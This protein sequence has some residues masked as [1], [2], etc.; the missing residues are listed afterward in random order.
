M[1]LSGFSMI[2]INMFFREGNFVLPRDFAV[3]KW[4][5]VKTD[6]FAAPANRPPA[7]SD[8]I[9]WA[10]AYEKRMRRFNLE[11]VLA[12]LIALTVAIASL[13]YSW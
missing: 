2:P 9:D 13:A 11:V 5:I 12:A 10:Q 7:M 1:R 3:G 4:S 8:G 6:R